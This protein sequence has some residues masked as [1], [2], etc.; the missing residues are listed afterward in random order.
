LPANRLPACEHN[1]P[2][3]GRGS[4]FIQIARINY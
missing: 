2:G 1:M 3:N 4:E